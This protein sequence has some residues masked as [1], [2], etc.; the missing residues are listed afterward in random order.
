MAFGGSSTSFTLP[1]THNQTLANDGGTLSQ[2]LTD[3]GAVTLFSLISGAVDPQTAIN[4]GNIAT[5]VTNIAT[6]ATNIATNVSAI[7]AIPTPAWNRIVN[8]SQTGGASNF[9][10]TGL[11]ST[12]KYLMFSFAGSFGGVD[13]LRVRF[14]SGGSIDIGNNYSWRSGKNGSFISS[15]GANTIEIMTSNSGGNNDFFLSGFIQL[16][17]PSD[18]SGTANS[19]IGNLY[20]SQNDTTVNNILTSFEWNNSA[21]PVTDIRFYANGGNDIRGTLNIWESED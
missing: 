9:D 1:H 12:K 8:Q 3:M 5:N 18:G 20:T 15:S 7:A 14:G 21:T 2:A 11:T 6:N 4:T 13:K 19:R 16:N 10:V 17:A